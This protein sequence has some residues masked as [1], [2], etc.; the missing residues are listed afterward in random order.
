MASGTT[1]T[2][3]GL[4]MSHHPRFDSERRGPGPR[5]S[6]GF[7]RPGDGPSPSPNPFQRR[8]LAGWHPVPDEPLP[9]GHFSQIKAQRASA[10]ERQRPRDARNSRMRPIQ[11]RG[12]CMPACHGARCRMPGASCTCIPNTATAPRLP[13]GQH[14]VSKSI[15]TQGPI[16]RTSR[17]LIRSSAGMAPLE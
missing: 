12:T 5:H 13:A 17:P 7:A 3:G 2:K 8:S 11:L 15:S 14:S 9:G 16:L 6:A 10:A 4:P 1:L